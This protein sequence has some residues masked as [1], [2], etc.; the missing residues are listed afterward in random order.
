MQSAIRPKLKTTS[1]NLFT[2]V[3]NVKAALDTYQITEP[4]RIPIFC[5]DESTKDLLLENLR[6]LMCAV[7]ALHGSL[8]PGMTS[9]SAGQN[10]NRLRIIQDVLVASHLPSLQPHLKVLEPGLDTVQ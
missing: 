1:S 6:R 4:R 8:V 2:A 9:P 5:A 7:R 3:S 10:L